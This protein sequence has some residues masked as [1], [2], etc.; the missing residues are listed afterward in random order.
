M[1]GLQNR[2][3][4]QHVQL[5]NIMKLSYYCELAFYLT[6]IIVAMQRGQC[7]Y[8]HAAVMNL[9]LQ[10]LSHFWIQPPCFDPVQKYHK[11]SDVCKMQFHE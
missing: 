3:Q 8:L 1:W 7:L 6:V 4:D 10:T 5:F 11:I 9:A 2:T